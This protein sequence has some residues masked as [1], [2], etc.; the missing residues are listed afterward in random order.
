MKKTICFIVCLIAIVGLSSCTP[1]TYLVSAKYEVCYPD[2]TKVYDSSVV[3]TSR[4]EPVVLCYSFNGTN[5]I[6]AIKNE[7][8]AD[9]TT[10]KEANK[11]S[12][13]MSSTAPMRLNS[14]FVE[15]IKGSKEVDYD[16]R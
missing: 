12:V 2:G 4:E 15:K 3:V 10:I 6:S 13:I 9:G 14:H 7:L 11:A 8:Y 5:Y 1:S 16:L